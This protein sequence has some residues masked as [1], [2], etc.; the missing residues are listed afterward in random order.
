MFLEIYSLK[1]EEKESKKKIE[2]V[3]EVSPSKIQEK[4]ALEAM[5]EVQLLGWIQ[6]PLRECRVPKRQMV[7]FIKKKLI[8]ESVSSKVARANRCTGP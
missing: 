8:P 5:H 6:G 4:F 1:Y 3:L 2:D 7:D